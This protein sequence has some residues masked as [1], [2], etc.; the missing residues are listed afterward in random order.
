MAKLCQSCS[1]PLSKDVKGGGTN[2]DGSL[3]DKYCSLCYQDGQFTMPDLTAGE[4]QDFCV[5]QLTKQ[6]VPKVMAW[7]FTR[8]IPKLE[9]WQS[10]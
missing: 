9:R 3:S 7:L 8:S 2:A 4:M 1:M 6:G 10:R 5:E